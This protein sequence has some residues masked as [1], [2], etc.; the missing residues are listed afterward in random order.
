MRL[1][2]ENSSDEHVLTWRLNC[3]ADTLLQY[4]E[5]TFDD[6]F[7]EEQRIRRN[8]K[9][10][11]HRIHALLY[12]VEPTSLG[13]KQ[14][15]ID[16]MKRLSPRVNIIPIIAKADGLT[17]LE[18]QV[19]KKKVGTFSLMAVDAHRPAVDPGG[20]CKEQR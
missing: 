19:F 13:L 15:D 2:R 10:E 14:F 16:V 12:F 18:L 11:D 7:E 17:E 9:F 8:P 5:K 20:R 1:T 6:V 4:L 3:R